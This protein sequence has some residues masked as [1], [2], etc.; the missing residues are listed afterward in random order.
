MRILL[1]CLT[2]YQP[3]WRV[4]I[5]ITLATVIA[6]AIVLA[7]PLVER[8]LIDGVVLA[9]RLDLLIPTMAIYSTLWLA[10]TGIHILNGTLRTYLGERLSQLLRQKIFTHSDAL[11][12]AF[13][14]REH[15]GRTM[16]LF[17]NDVPSLVGLLSGTLFSTLGSL[18]VLVLAA[19]LMFDMS[20]Q[21]ALVV[22]LVPPLVGGLGA[23]V[24]RPLR[25]AAR[26]VQEKAAELSERIQEN[27]AG[28]REIVAFGREASEG[29]RFWAA[30][31][32]LLRL[33]MRLAYMDTGLQTGQTVFSLAITLVILGYG[34]YLVT[35]GLVTIGTLFAIRSLFNYMFTSVSQVFGAVGTIQKTL[36]A[37]DRIYAF[38]DQR[39]TVQEY[40]GARTPDGVHG[41]VTFEQVSFSY[42]PGRPVLHDVSFTARPGEVVALVGPSGAGKTTVASLIARFYDPGSG[43]V[44]LDGTDLRDLTLE[45]LRS[46]IGMVFQDSFLFATTIRENIA[47]GRERASE[48]E[49]VSAA[50]AA[51]VWEFIEAL[52]DGLDTV[53]GQRGVQL[54]EGQKQR[55]AIARALLRDPRILILDEPT[56][57]LDARSE[58]LLQTALDVLI[59]GRTTFVIA[60]RLATAARADLILVL[61]RGRIV[62]QGTHGE[63]LE[64]RGLYHELYEL[65]FGGRDKAARRPALAL[66]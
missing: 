47:V 49:V 5:P 61:D 31:S 63:L 43:R 15:S 58:H 50:R 54:S 34:G 53:V 13:S 6:P 38:L 59:A 4:C 32:E 39:P 24:T 11:S 19:A 46:Q 56:S 36:A 7:I 37:A 64:R 20:W 65:Q 48:A 30:Q 40:P 3:V 8:Q 16:A 62:E 14:H 9:Q 66:T 42:Q 41:A 23:F 22:A 21:L 52:P 55:V 12:L 10:M 33:R 28:V 60:H 29:R 45:G 25:P 35:Q 44:L 57:A 17:A 1:R 27:L 18:I 26:R 51:N 2:L